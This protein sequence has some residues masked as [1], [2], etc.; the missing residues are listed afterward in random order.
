ML[1][2]SAENM[3]IRCALILP[4]FLVG[5]A[6]MRDSTAIPRTTLAYTNSAF[7]IHL[8][9]MILRIESG[10]LTAWKQYKAIGIGL[11]GEHSQTY[12]VGCAEILARDPTFFLRRHLAGDENAAP[13]ALRAYQWSR[14]ESRRLVSRLYEL[15][16]GL[17]TE[18]TTRKK[19]AD[20][21]EATTKSNP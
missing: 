10:D 16:I 12:S 11:D 9:K 18:P 2:R 8:S 4:T 1:K 17:E 21:I 7:S 13:M 15:R 19:I 3:L 5:C 14:P 6:S 20:F